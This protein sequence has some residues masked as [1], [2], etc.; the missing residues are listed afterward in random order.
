MAES[1]P[2]KNKPT[3][4]A[5]DPLKAAWDE[6]QRLGLEPYV[7]ELD[8]NGLTVIPPEIACPGDLK[9][10]LLEAIL[11]TAEDEKGFRPDLETGKTLKNYKGRYASEESGGDSP[12]GA[13]L[14]CMVLKGRVFEEALMNPVHLAMATYL[15]GYSTILSSM[16]CFMKGPNET[17]LDLHSDCFLPDPWPSHAM[18]SASTYLLTDFSREDGCTAYVPGSHRLCRR[19]RPEEISIGE[20][21]NPNAV[22]VE[23]KAGSLMVWH[24]NT[25]HGAYNRTNKGVRVS[26]NMLLARPHM[27]TEEDLADRVP[28]EV[29]DRN[30]A[31]FAILTHQGL[32]YGFTSGED[33]GRR[34]ERASKYQMEYAEEN[35]GLASVNPFFMHLHG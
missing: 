15:C 30:S 20:G 12:F 26:L 35:G 13:L 33:A 23:G 8:V 10:R 22:P 18:L 3:E 29:L 7:A 5:P 31:R 2:M 32:F 9:S 16:T 24:G 11:D 1:N 19:P 14:Q 28:E 34:V 27:R 17:C 25:W 21:G 6:I 4:A